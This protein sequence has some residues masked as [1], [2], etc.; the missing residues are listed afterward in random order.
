[1]TAAR[2]SMVLTMVA[3]VVVLEGQ[4]PRAPF[5]RSF[6]GPVNNLTK[7]SSGTGWADYDNDGDLDLFIAAFENEHNVLFENLGQG[8]FRAAAGGPVTTDAGLS[9]GAAWADFD[10]DGNE[11]LAVANQQWQDN[12]LY[13]G[14][15]R[16]RFERVTTSPVATDGGNSYGVSWADVDNDGWLDLHVANMSGPRDFLY[17]NIQGKGFARMPDSGVETRPGGTFTSTWAD[18]DDDGRADLFAANASSQTPNKLY[19]NMG[20]GTFEVVSTG[21]IATDLGISHGG[22]WGDYDNDGDLDLYVANGG[23]A[24]EQAQSAFFY[25]NEGR[26]VFIKITTGPLVTDVFS[27]MSAVW[28]DYDNDADLDLVVG[29]YREHNRLYR[30]EGNRTFT[31][32]T[33]GPL[34]SYGGYNDA[35]AAADFNR[36]GALD[37]MVTHWEHQ[38]PWL[39]TNEGNTNRWL[40][41]RLIG[42]R[43]NRSAIGARVYASAAIRGTTV[44]QTRHVGS[45]TGGRGQ[46]AREVHFG[47]ADATHVAELR[48]VWPSGAETVLRDLDTNQLHTVEETRG[49]VASTPGVAPLQRDAVSAVAQA[50]T[51][52][53]VDALARAISDGRRDDPA[54][55][56]AGAVS[57]VAQSLTDSEAAMALAVAQLAAREFPASAVAQFRAAEI[58]RRANRT[59]EARVL[60]CAALRLAERVPAPDVDPRELN[61][62]RVNARRYLGTTGCPQPAR[63]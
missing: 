48:I 16:G 1:M 25:R 49:V 26:G 4:Q 27:G 58:H 14:R 59:E 41:L 24:A 8:R 28:F 35:L 2:L 43:S 38:N 63:R 17:R 11:D 37:L 46:S 18:F 13:R 39:L 54:S 53:G 36:D 42:T 62:V 6:D 32:I 20:D 34:V 30:N 19:R 57:I 31:R 61:H 47:M 55:D 7:T 9:S 44:R 33:T 22:A 23:F 56:W 60:Y 10:N 15:G 40:M 45:E 50:L 5:A 51:S 3:G 52:G 21:P 12:F 29:A